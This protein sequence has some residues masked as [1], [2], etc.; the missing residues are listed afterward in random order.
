MENQLEKNRENAMETT[1]SLQGSG[2]SLAISGLG[3]ALEGSRCLQCRLKA[4]CRAL[5]VPGVP[6]P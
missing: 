6:K 2:R 1:T 5:K 3:L 4:D